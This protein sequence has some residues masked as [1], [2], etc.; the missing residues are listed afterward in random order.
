MHIIF[1]LLWGIWPGVKQRVD[2]EKCF[3]GKYIPCFAKLWEY[4]LLSKCFS[5]QWEYHKFILKQNNITCEF[6]SHIIDAIEIFRLFLPSWFFYWNFWHNF[7]FSSI[8]FIINSRIE[9]KE[10][11]RKKILEQI[12]I[13]CVCIKITLKN[14]IPYKLKMQQTNH[15]SWKR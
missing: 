9:T 7:I 5:R 11:I 15:I 8:P 1:Y 10:K 14:C 13:I 6:E 12:V 2:E 4:N 3:I